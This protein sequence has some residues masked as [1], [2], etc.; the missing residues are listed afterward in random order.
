MQD[1]ESIRCQVVRMLRMLVEITST[2]DRMPEE[3]YLLMKV[4]P[5]AP[6]LRS[7]AV[8]ATA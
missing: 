8:T 6:G 4:E 7:L 3:R 2:L 1:P 5:T